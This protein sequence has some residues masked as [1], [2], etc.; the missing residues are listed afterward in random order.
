MPWFKESFDVVTTQP[1]MLNKETKQMEKTDKM[2]L[3]TLCFN[4]F[5]LMNIF[6]MLNCRVNTN[7]VNIFSN[8]FNNMYFWLIVCFEFAVQVAFIWWTKNE[9]I[10]KFLFTNSQEMSMIIT[11]WTIGALVLPVRALFV[12]AIPPSAFGFMSKLN[13]ETDTNDNCVT[14]CYARIFRVKNQE[15]DDYEKLQ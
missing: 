3:N 9:M 7:E 14:K 6:N 2:E 13:L 15:G 1:F 12:K 11:A 5:M 4:T 8:L 10:S